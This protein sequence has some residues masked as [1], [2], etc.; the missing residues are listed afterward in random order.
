MIMAEQSIALYFSRNMVKVPLETPTFFG[1]VIIHGHY[2]S[3]Y[4]LF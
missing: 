3:V 1:Y 2:Y 4:V